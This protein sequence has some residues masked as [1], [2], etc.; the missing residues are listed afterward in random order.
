V[1]TAS[2]A[3][4]TVIGGRLDQWRVE[5]A[6]GC[7]ER[8]TS[9][10][11]ASRR[12][13]A[14]SRDRLLLPSLTLWLVR[15]AAPGKLHGPEWWWLSASAVLAAG[16]AQTPD[17]ELVGIARRQAGRYRAPGRARRR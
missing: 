1:P 11:L 17:I 14:V 16:L 13:A 15:L 6:T 7:P 3:G 9:A 8:L 2:L 10:R 5:Q 4:K 12:V